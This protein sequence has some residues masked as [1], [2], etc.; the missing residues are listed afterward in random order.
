MNGMFLIENK[1]QREAFME[2]CCATQTARQY[3]QELWH[4]ENL[5]L[6]KN[7]INAQLIIRGDM[8][9]TF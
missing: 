2:I 4:F 5:E 9:K 7:R 1:K 8:T 6:L 3:S